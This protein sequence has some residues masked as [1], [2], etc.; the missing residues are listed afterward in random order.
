MPRGRPRKLTPSA[1]AKPVIPVE[2]STPPATVNQVITIN[3]EQENIELKV[4][5]KKLEEDV[6]YYKTKF[7]Q[8]NRDTD[9]LIEALSDIR[10]ITEKVGLTF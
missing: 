3:L 2:E 1:E 9:N 6:N 8:W 5:I 7:I 4:R 10:T